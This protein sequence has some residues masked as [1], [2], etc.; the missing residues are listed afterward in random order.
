[1][2]ISFLVFLFGLFLVLGAYLL[3]TRGS[4]AKRARLQKRLSDALLHSSNTEDV[5]VLLAR[6]ELMSEI[7][8]LNRVLVRV[9]AALQLKRMLDQADLHITPSR[10]AMFS[11]MA[12]ILAALAAS[13]IRPSILLMLVCGLL[14]ALL[15]FAHV[16]WKRKKRFDQFLEYLPDALD[17]MS[18]GLSAGHAFSE[19]LHMVS[20]EMPE[21]IATEFR[22][23]YEE[24]NLG[25]SLKLALENLIQRIPLLD[26]RMCVTAILI[27]RE[28][29][30]NLA[31]IL[32]KVAYTIRERFRIMGDL[33]TLTTSSRMSAWL[34]CGLP[35]FVSIAITVMNPEY[36][37]VLWKD[38]RGH[39]LI[40]TALFMQITGMLI[41]R[42]ILRIKI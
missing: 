41:V 31:E 11:F 36:M 24:Q 4:D 9:Q 23:T 12:G 6:N 27:Q 26:L 10:L 38:S 37:S 30:G 20:E 17:L 3:A 35:I 40:A 32:E 7:P 34:L 25:L 19:A 5:E 8:W 18:R 39:Y 14:A 16:W 42:K 13:V 21:P 28:T 33:K 2:L 22:K 1:M 15:P 29:G